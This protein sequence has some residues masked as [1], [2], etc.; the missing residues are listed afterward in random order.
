MSREP[1]ILIPEY[2]PDHCDCHHVITQPWNR[3]IMASSLRFLFAFSFRSRVQV[4]SYYKM[5]RGFF[6][7][8]VPRASYRA[9]LAQILCGTLLG[10]A[11][12]DSRGVFPISIWGLRNGV[13]LGG[14]PGVKNLENTPFLS[15]LIEI[16]KTPRLSHVESPKRLPCKI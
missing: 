2:G 8:T 6:Y 5:P 7:Q 14:P 15:P 1:Q 4:D 10:D 3:A 12:W 13:S 16:R 11:T 9:E